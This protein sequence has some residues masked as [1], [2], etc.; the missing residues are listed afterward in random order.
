M[1]AGITRR[2][3]LG[4]SAAASAMTALPALAMV[5]DDA[6]LWQTLDGLAGLVD[7]A[8]KLAAL[9]RFRA[10]RL[11]LARRLDLAVV[12][13]GLTIDRRLAAQPASIARARFAL[14]LARGIGREMPVAAARAA[15]EA[16]RDRLTRAALPLFDALGISA[17]TLG[18][19]YRRLFADPR[20]LYPDGEA[21][22]AQAV[23]DMT[24][25]LDH[26]RKALP[27]WFGAVP[28]RCLNV[29]VRALT[30]EESAAG[31]G[32]YRILPT[33]TERG[34]YIVDLEHIAR[35]PRWTL[36][37]VV[38]HELLP[39]HMV[40]LPI[41]ALA[42]PHPL[43]LHYAGAF[44]EGWGA[45]AEGLAWRGGLLPDPLDRLGAIH[46]LLFRVLRGIADIGLNHDAW[47][48]DRAQ[49]L[50][51]DG[52]G[53]PAYFAAFADDLARMTKEPATRAAEALVALGLTERVQ[54]ARDER[55]LHTAWLA[56]GAHYPADRGNAYS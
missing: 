1:A 56:G 2:T 49:A 24:G 32:G 13:Y 22:R 10:D 50:L 35:R 53:E 45:Y 12:R 39:G 17:P 19:R 15:L 44:V 3:A 5:N 23:A 31:K 52:Q 29:G 25:W 4:W 18:A 34:W 27:R 20:H 8:A 26:A 28:P 40:Q 37:S 42:G 46:W 11:S 47:S 7:P 33:D 6:A 38:H 9:A 21:G 36:H 48:L 30:P 41:Q 54:T 14:L 16:E 43:R 55:R 51:E